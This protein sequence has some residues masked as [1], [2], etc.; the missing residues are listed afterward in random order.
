MASCVAFICATNLSV[1]SSDSSFSAS[2]FAKG[3]ATSVSFAT[4][5]SVAVIFS[6]ASCMS[7]VFF[8]VSVSFLKCASFDAEELILSVSCANSSI[9]AFAISVPNCFTARFLPAMKVR[10]VEIAASTTET[11]SSEAL[12]AL[13]ASVSGSTSRPLRKG[14]SA[15]LTFSKAA[16]TSATFALPSR[17]WAA[18]VTRSRWSF[19]NVKI[20]LIEAVAALHRSESFA[21]AAFSTGGA[22][23]KF[24]STILEDALRVFWASVDIVAIASMS[25]SLGFAASMPRAAISSSGFTFFKAFATSSSTSLSFLSSSTS[26]S[27]PWISFSPVEAAFFAF[28][29]SPWAVLMRPCSFAM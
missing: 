28:C 21:N 20:S 4:S 10:A 17:T 23:A 18:L 27:L 2:A 8:L 11:A 24:A 7:A 6:P 25:S 13:V 19:V 3:S 12:V 15:S 14:S 9:A 22:P 26:T 5:A 1:A 29:K 16:S